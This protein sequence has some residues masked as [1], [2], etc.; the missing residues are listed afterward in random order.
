M[1]KGTS[2][3]S[4][5]NI[6]L[7]EDYIAI[8]ERS[9]LDMVQ[10]T[11]DFSQN[12]NF[13]NLQNIVIDNSGWKSFL[14]N[15]SAFIIAMIATTNIPQYKINNDDID[16]NSD[17]ELESEKV[18]LVTGELLDL[19]AYW[20]ELLKRSNYNGSLLSEIN[21]L[22]YSV[23]ES[24]VLRFKS[25]V[26]AL[27][28]TYDTVY[29]NVVFIKE[30][31]VKKFE[32]EVLNESN[33]HP[34]VGLLLAFFKLFKNVQQD[35]NSITKKHLDFYFL[36][37][38][39]QERKKLK[40]STAIIGL[41]LQ[42]GT[43][44]L[45]IN[46]GDPCEFVFEGKQ[47]YSFIAESTTQINKAEIAEIRTLYKSDYHPFGTN[48][49]DDGFSINHIFEA[50]VITD[51]NFRRNPE[52]LEYENF[53]AILGE[54]QLLDDASGGIIKQSE[55]GILIS[56]PALILEKGK[57]NISL[58]FKIASFDKAKIMF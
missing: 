4:R 53:P 16:Y 38:L 27:K 20:A 52:V 2:Q 24:N 47:R 45:F 54:E 10:F 41:Q 23:N 56:S 12:V 18:K 14:L 28:E 49:E 8:D 50:L 57:Q 6:A 21:K 22:L 36:K 48:F 58:I 29:G 33:H 31:A 25:D 3:K 32:D 43:E 5:K 51:G 44:D 9:L 34:H 7:R 11:L 13:Y 55:V 39:Q 46:E 35:I 15:D 1:N 40:P 37:L 17:S 26:A 19:I 30:N 42:Q